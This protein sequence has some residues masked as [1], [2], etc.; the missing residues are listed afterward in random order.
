MSYY[1][2]LSVF[3]SVTDDSRIGAEFAITGAAAGAKSAAGAAKA[4]ST[5]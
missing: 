2:S 3:S 4:C 5:P 1:P